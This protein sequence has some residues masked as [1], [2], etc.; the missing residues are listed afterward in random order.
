M[1]TMTA[2]VQLQNKKECSGR[3]LKGL[4]AKRNCLAVNRQK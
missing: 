1:M 4:G 3:E 2:R